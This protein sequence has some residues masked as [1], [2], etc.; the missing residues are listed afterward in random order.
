[1]TIH[2]WTH[3]ASGSF[4][5]K[6]K[7]ALAHIIVRCLQY[8]QKFNNVEADSAVVCVMII[9]VALVALVVLVSKR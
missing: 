5:L 4:K 8:G 2:Q 3:L 9:L 7:N 6:V 1:M